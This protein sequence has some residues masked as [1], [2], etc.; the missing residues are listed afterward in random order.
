[1]QG[2]QFFFENS[3]FLPTKSDKMMISILFSTGL[4]MRSFFENI[5]SGGFWYM[6]L[7]LLLSPHKKFILGSG[8][9]K[10]QSKQIP[11]KAPFFG[12]EYLQ[13]KFQ[14]FSVI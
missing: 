4:N 2:L 12:F 8:F 13:I 11:L 5:F 3:Y 14:C 7:L 9:D 1:M 10:K 6:S